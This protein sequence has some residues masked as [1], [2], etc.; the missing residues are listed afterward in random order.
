MLFT[1]ETIQVNGGAELM[2][3]FER[4]C[5]KSSIA[6][7]MLRPRSSK[8]NGNVEHAFGTWRYMFPGCWMVPDSLD[9]FDLLIDAFAGEFNR[10][11]PLMALRTSDAGGPERS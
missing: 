5:R 8:L 6:L 11:K 4:Q 9:R 3:G 1:I 10:V 2:A 7:R